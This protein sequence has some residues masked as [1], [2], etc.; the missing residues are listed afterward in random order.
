MGVGPIKSSSDSNGG[1]N[2]QVYGDTLVVSNT[3]VELSVVLPLD[4]EDQEPML[5]QNV[6]C[7]VSGLLA[8]FLKKL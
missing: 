1:D 7:Y 6:D 4:I 2:T 3:Q 8:S 5:D